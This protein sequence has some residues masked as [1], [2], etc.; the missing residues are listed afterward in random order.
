MF[1]A[2]P[3]EHARTD[4]R[5]WCMYG[6][7]LPT[8]RSMLSKA[9]VRKLQQSASGKLLSQGRETRGLANTLADSYLGAEDFHLD[10]KAARM[11]WNVWV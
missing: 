1:K 8:A 5:A 11:L 3:F 9:G 7:S 10:E 2:T 6:C 4:P